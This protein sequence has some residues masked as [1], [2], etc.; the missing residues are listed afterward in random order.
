MCK[1]AM[2]RGHNNK[3]F[4]AQQNSDDTA[5]IMQLECVRGRQNEIKMTEILPLNG[6]RIIDLDWDG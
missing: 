3:I 4:F 6:G 5:K 2:I 1:I